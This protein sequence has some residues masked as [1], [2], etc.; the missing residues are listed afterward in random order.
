MTDKAV[1]EEA[2]KEVAVYSAVHYED[3]YNSTENMAKEM[4]YNILENKLFSMYNVKVNVKKK[5]SYIIVTA[6]GEFEVPMFA[7]LRK[8]IWGEDMVLKVEGQ[9][10]ITKPVRTI[11]GAKFIENII[12][13][14]N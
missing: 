8:S 5:G 7:Q 9:G 12:E 3:D 13:G 14:E 1:L 2:V 6:E 11:W 4:F 10:V